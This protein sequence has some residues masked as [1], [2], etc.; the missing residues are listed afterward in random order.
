MTSTTTTTLTNLHHHHYHNKHQ[1]HYRHNHNHHRHHHHCNHYHNHCHYLY[2]KTTTIQTTFVKL[3]PPP[4]AP[5]QLQ[6]LRAQPP[7]SFGC[8]CPQVKESPNFI[9]RCHVNP[10]ANSP[11]PASQYTSHKDGILPV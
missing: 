10:R 8:S 7:P 3:A 6:Q 5:P 2:K 9:G 11:P 1:N 4:T